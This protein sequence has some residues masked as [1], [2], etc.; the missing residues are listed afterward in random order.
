MSE[1]TTLRFPSLQLLLTSQSKCMCSVD[2]IDN[3]SRGSILPYEIFLCQRIIMPRDKLVR[4]CYVFL[5]HSC[6]LA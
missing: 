6:L 4:V 2:G 3:L 5:E 1:C